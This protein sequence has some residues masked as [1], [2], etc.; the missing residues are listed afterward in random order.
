M[1]S[2]AKITSCE[3]AFVPI[4]SEDYIS[5]VDKVLDIIRSYDLEH[6]IGIMSTT[7]RGDINKIHKLI[8]EIYDKMD[9]ECKFTMDIKLSN[10]CGC[11]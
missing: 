5:S 3:I 8:F 11:D 4:V 9:Q 1:C 10:L 7:V 2:M 6:N